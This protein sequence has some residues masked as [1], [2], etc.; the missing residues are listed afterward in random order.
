DRRPRAVFFQQVEKGEPLTTVLAADGV[1]SG[2]IQYDAFGGE[3]PVAIAGAANPLHHTVAVV[4]KGKLESGIKNGGA[5]PRR[6]IADDHMPRQ[7]IKRRLAF[8]NT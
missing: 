5:F 6:R 2:G 8:E 1:T 3:V 4:L 7:L